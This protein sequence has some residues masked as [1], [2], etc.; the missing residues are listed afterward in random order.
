MRR[1]ALRLTAPPGGFPKYGYF[2]EMP[3][4]LPGG[5]T[6]ATS[7]FSHLPFP[8]LVDG[9]ELIHLEPAWNSTPYEAFVLYNGWG[10]IVAEW[11]TEP[12]F[13]EL[14]EY[15]PTKGNYES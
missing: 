3:L 14:M 11:G 4:G 8:L 13:G 10:E 1:Q 9:Y 15:A 2:R 12:S 5:Q 6:I 7:F